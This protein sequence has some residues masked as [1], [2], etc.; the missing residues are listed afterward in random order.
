MGARTF[1]Y[2]LRV[3]LCSCASTC[4]RVA[5]KFMEPAEGP[6]PN[7][8]SLACKSSQVSQRCSP[9]LSPM[10][11]HAANYRPLVDKFPLQAWT[12]VLMMVWPL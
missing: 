2:P 1:C 4:K 9:S 7:W 12:S 10:A 5:T 8:R 11:R 3:T 6:A